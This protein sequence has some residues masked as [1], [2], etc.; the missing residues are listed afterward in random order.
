MIKDVTGIVPESLVMQS[1]I[2]SIIHIESSLVGQKHIQVKILVLE[3][4][5]PSSI[6]FRYCVGIHYRIGSLVNGCATRRTYI[7]STIGVGPVKLSRRCI[8]LI[9]NA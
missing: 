2:G 5:I 4:V 8:I 3:S 9:K 1:R 7:T 6:P